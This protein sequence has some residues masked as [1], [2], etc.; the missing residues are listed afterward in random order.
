M[1]KLLISDAAKQ[2]QVESH[3]LRYWEEE[4]HLPIQRNKQG[5]RYY[6]VE[7]VNRF[8]QIKRMK[9]QGFQLKAIRNALEGTGPQ[10]IH[11]TVGKSNVT[12]ID[13]KPVQSAEETQS[14]KRDNTAQHKDTAD[15]G[16][17]HTEATKADAMKMNTADQDSEAVA[18]QSITIQNIDIQ[19]EDVHKTDLS[20]EHKESTVGE[21]AGQNSKGLLKKGKQKKR[22]QKKAA[23][24]KGISTIAIQRFGLQKQN[25]KEQAEKQI[26][27]QAENAAVE[28][29]KPETE[30][31]KTETVKEQQQE[32]AA[33][34]T[35]VIEQS[36][37]VLGEQE[38][39]NKA[40]RLQFLLQHMISEA[41]RENNEQL[42]TTVKE[43]V[44][45][46]MDY[47]F[48]QQEEREQE[49]EKERLKREEEHYKQIDLLL[50]GASKKERRKKVFSLQ[51]P[52][53]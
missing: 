37:A 47:Q 6:T 22:A 51:K 46:E 38:R 27:G 10:E 18:A 34:Q 12:M 39:T 32:G 17:M 28:N 3:V 11:V 15:A 14:D 45:K 41:V 42:Y 24:K 1:E 7:D 5:H 40:A 50:R 36:S 48:R 8:Q 23:Q 19:N 20:A 21:V 16:A 52:S 31:E 2:V 29:E 26:T 9:E 30:T 4:L 33:A 43:T 49:R 35:V 53:L 25:E 13:A 44:A